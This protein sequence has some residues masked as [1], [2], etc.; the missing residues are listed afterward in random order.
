MSSLN[1]QVIATRL[2]V[3][4]NFTLLID[5]GVESSVAAQIVKKYMTIAFSEVR[6]SDDRIVICYKTCS[7]RMTLD[8]TLVA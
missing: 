6:V 1:A 8:Y 7:A 3:A 2:R 5:S 4:K